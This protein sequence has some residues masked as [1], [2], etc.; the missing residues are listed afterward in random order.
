[1]AGLTKGHI[2]EMKALGSPPVLVILTSKVVMTLLGERFGAN[3]PDEKVWKK[4]ATN[5]NNP[6]KFLEQII[7]FNGES[8]DTGI[9]ES[10]GK[11]MANPQYN[12]ETMKS[13]NF[14]AMMLCS[15]S[16]NIVIFNRIFKNVAPLVASKNAAQA[17]LEQKQKDL[18]IVKEKVRILNEKV[19]ALKNQ[20]EEA[21][22]TKQA[23]E[24]DAAN[25][26]AKLSAA[27]KLV[28]GLAGE[29]KRWKE[30]VK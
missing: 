21:E 8:I 25:C 30:T 7:N 16:V 4:A 18:A 29:N 27:I 15:W 24:K 12:V 14:A 5:M 3:D 10:V 19:G 2:G 13:Q 26:E 6:M 23:V 1:M 11:L 28:N 20:L 17:T 9:L 22:A